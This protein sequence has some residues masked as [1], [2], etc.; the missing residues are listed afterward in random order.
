MRV[1]I[2]KR[3]FI[4]SLIQIFSELESLF[5]S[6]RPEFQLLSLGATEW[7]IRNVALVACCKYAVALE[8]RPL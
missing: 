4:L 2:N 7:D 6:P 8:S 1:Q 3:I 5:V